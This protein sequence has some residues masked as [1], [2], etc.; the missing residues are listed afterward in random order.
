M[1]RST[2]ISLLL[3]M[4]VTACVD[5]DD[6]DKQTQKSETDDQDDEET[7]PDDQA[8]SDPPVGCRASLK[9]SDDCNPT[10]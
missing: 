6:S 5:Q 1:L 10:P 4:G 7:P 9:D 3:A 8:P 2:A